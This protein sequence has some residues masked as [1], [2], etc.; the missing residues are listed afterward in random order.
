MIWQYVAWVVLAAV[1]VAAAVF[2]LRRGTVYNW[3]TYPAIVAGLALGAIQGFAAGDTAGG[4]IDHLI[5]FGFGFGILLV[6]YV[7]GGMGGGDVK[8]MGAV[9][10]LLGWRDWAVL[11]AV[12]YSF[13]VGAALG[14]ILMVWRGR[15]RIVL[16]RLW[17]AVRILPLPT[18]TLDEAT[19]TPTLHVPFGFAVCVGT[20]W[21][22]AERIFGESLWDVAGR[23]V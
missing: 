22:L 8:L 7:V 12:V 15:V 1:L 17:M 9:G 5:G 3:L 14:L 16:R 19:G 13:L 4:L 23:L 2:D 10:A 20:L 6:A 21:Y 18:A 11:D